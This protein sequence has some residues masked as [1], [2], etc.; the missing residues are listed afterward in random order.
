MKTLIAGTALGLSLLITSPAFAYEVKSGDT[1]YKIAKEH[2]VS[3]Q[4]LSELN[5]QIN[6]I[7]RIYVGQ[8]VNTNKAE[9]TVKPVA[10]PEPTVNMSAYE[11][12][13]LARLVRAEAE[14]ESYAGKVAVAYVVLNRVDSNQFPNSVSA[15]INQK[16][17]FSPVSNGAIN[18]PADAESKRA[19]EEAI[20]ANRADSES[21]FFYNANTASSRWLDSRETTVVI[22]NHTFKK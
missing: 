11:K 13:L 12:D 10:K 16:G 21:L 1:M 15:V 5:P 3:L 9:P 18:T 4:E 6:N 8:N 2:N 20:T 19:V 14:A 17:Q 22:G 7:N